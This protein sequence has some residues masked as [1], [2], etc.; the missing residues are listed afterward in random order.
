MRVDE[1]DAP[2]DARDLD[3]LRA[4]EAAEAMVS[5]RGSRN[6]ETGDG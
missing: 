4:I 1:I 6:T 5:K 3:G 2:N